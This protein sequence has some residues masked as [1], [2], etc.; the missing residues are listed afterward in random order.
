[1]VNRTWRAAGLILLG[2]G[3]LT[4][5][6]SAQAR[7]TPV[8]SGNPTPGTPQP[9]PPRLE[10][11][12]TLTGCVRAAAA[13]AGRGAAAPVDPNAPSDSRFVLENAARE[14]R[15]PPGTG[16][17]S[18]AKGPASKT[19]R[20]AAVNSA[21]QPFVGAQ[22]EISGE[23]EAAPPAAPGAPAPPPLLRVAFVQKVAPRCP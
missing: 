13:A 6:I 12:I 17:S 1:M 20:L 22:V 11:R 10:D 14:A 21:L 3:A 23:V 8:L 4:T 16:T 2:V 19:Y 15:V 5:T 18:A 9:D 7:G